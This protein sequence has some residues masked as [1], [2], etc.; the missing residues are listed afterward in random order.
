MTSITKILWQI[1]SEINRYRE[2]MFTI[3]SNI[4]LCTQKTQVARQTITTFSSKHATLESQIKSL[5]AGPSK[6]KAEDDLHK[7]EMELETAKNS[8]S[9]EE[10]TC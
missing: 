8:M 6:N 3:Q 1:Q 9:V 7:I 4:D 5:K 2:H 10:A